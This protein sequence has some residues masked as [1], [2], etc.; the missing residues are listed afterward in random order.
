[1]PLPGTR[2]IPAGWSAHHAPV[3]A[4]AMN[5]KAQV[6]DPELRTKGWD[7]DT[8]SP[9]VVDGPPLYDG[10]CAVMSV[11]SDATTLQAD[12]QVSTREYLVRFPYAVPWLREGLEV[13]FAEAIN[14]PGLVGRTMRVRDA[15]L[16]SERFQRDV[17]C[18][19]TTEE[20]S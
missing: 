13:K 15:Q 11:Q 17:I 4:G 8:E 5:A 3:A 14:D 7:D 16:G 20:A 10:P 6:L 12:E 18:V 19:D 2:V 1:M 9:T